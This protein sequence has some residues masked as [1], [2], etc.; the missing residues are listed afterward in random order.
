[1][2]EA[3]EAVEVVK[4]LPHKLLTINEVKSVRNAVDLPLEAVAV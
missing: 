3:V 4:V 1:V 2:V